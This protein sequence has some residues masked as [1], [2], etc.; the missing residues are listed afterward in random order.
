M[1]TEKGWEHYN[2]TTELMNAPIY[3]LNKTIVERFK[4]QALPSVV[5]GQGD[6]VVVR[7][8]DAKVLN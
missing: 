6:G 7:E 1:D 5:Q 4:I 2:Q 8:I 3:K